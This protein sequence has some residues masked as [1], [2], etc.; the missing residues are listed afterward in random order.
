MQAIRLPSS[1]LLFPLNR[2]FSAGHEYDRHPRRSR[3]RCSRYIGRRRR[4]HDQELGWR[5]RKYHAVFHLEPLQLTMTKP[6]LDG[7]A[8]AIQNHLVGIVNRAFRLA[9]A[10]RRNMV[11]WADLVQAFE[12]WFGGSIC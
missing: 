12:E 2:P 1:S 10:N 3:L 5:V 4:Q 7:A 6:A 11:N 9:Q 8:A